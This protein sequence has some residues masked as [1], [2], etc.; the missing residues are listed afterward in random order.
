MW[1]SNKWFTDMHW[2][3]D[4]TL[5]SSEVGHFT[6]SPLILKRQEGYLTMISVYMYKYISEKKSPTLK[7]PN[8]KRKKR[9]QIHL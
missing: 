5:N 4:H 2:S 1:I 6:C 8:K 3:I 9:K 7:N